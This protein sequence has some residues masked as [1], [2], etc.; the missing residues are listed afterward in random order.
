MGITG[1]V[2]ARLLLSIW[3]SSARLGCGPHDLVASGESDPGGRSGSCE[4]SHVLCPGSETIPL[5]YRV[6]EILYSIKKPLDRFA[7][8]PD[9]DDPGLLD[10]VEM[11]IVGDQYSISIKAGGSVDDI[12]K[13]AF[14]EKSCTGIYLL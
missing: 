3:P 2:V 5:S 1:D 14:W 13:L 12:R 9:L 11:V 7:A 10:L 8:A 4:V 6:L